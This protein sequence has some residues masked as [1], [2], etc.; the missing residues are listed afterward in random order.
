MK[1]IEEIY[2]TIKGF[3]RNLSHFIK[4]QWF[5]FVHVRPSIPKSIIKTYKEN[6]K[7]FKTKNNISPFYWDKYMP[8]NALGENNNPNHKD[9]LIVNHYRLWTYLGDYM[10]Y[11]LFGNTSFPE[12]K[13]NYFSQ[14]NLGTFGGNKIPKKECYLC[15]LFITNNDTC[16]EECA[17]LW[18]PFKKFSLCP[19]I[20]SYYGLLID[21]KLTKYQKAL[22][23]YMIA[24]LP[25][26]CMETDF[27]KNHLLADTSESK[28]DEAYENKRN[29]IFEPEPLFKDFFKEVR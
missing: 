29:G 25:L 21:Y 12:F 6:K 7:I 22:I 16:E 26:P 18:K 8:L 23:C 27:Y 5:Y 19:C 28:I 9:R 24:S 3:T 20:R 11:E 17:N 4:D 10:L 14:F 2:L 1:K 15:E 13:N